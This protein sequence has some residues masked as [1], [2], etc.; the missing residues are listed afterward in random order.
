V[1]KQVPLV[2]LSVRN[3]ALHRYVLVKQDPTMKEEAAAPVVP[4]VPVEGVQN[5]E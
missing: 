3:R 5:V 1:D 2:L 4:A